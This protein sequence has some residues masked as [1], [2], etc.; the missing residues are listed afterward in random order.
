M[1]IPP[2]VVPRRAEA[3][4]L[5]QINPSG[6]VNFQGRAVGSPPQVRASSTVQQPTPYIG[7]TAPDKGLFML[8]EGLQYFN[9]EIGKLAFTQ[10]KEWESGQVEKG[11]TDAIVDPAKV[12]EVFKIGLD[13][14]AEQGLFPK[15]AHPSYRFAY[16]QQGAEN[17]ALTGLPAFLEDRAKALTS[18]DSTEPIES[19]LNTSIDEF[20]NNSGITSSPMA[21]AAFREAAFPS[22][23]RVVADTR[24]KR[25]ENF[26][27]ARLEGLEQNINGQTTGL[28]SSMSIEKESDR[29]MATGLALRNLQTTFDNIRKNYPEVNATKQFTSSFLASLNASVSNG[30]LNPREAMQVVQTAAASLKA[31]TGAW[32]DIADVQY[33]ISGIMATW[34][35]KA[36]SQGNMAQQQKNQ[37]QALL[38]ETISDV[39]EKSIV[40][41]TFTQLNSNTDLEAIGVA[42]A[43]EVYP[44]MA[45]KTDFLRRKVRELKIETQER[46]ENSQKFFN[47][48]PALE[49]LI[50]EDPEMARARLNANRSSIN[51]ETYEKYDKKINEVN[52]IK[53]FL[54][55]GGYAKKLAEIEPMVRDSIAPK[56][57][58]FE[59]DTLTSEE[60]EKI[61]DL[62]SFGEQTFR[63]LST[64]FLR[65]ELMENPA[66]RQDQ[67]SRET[68][69]MKA[70]NQAWI[71]TQKRMADYQSKSEKSS[72]ANDPNANPAKQKQQKA[73]IYGTFVRTVSLLE[74]AVDNMTLSTD[75]T[76][77]QALF[78]TLT[79]A[80][81]VDLK[82]RLAE[83]P[84]ELNSIAAKMGMLVPS[85]PE[86]PQAVASYNKII[87]IAG[88]GAQSVIKGKTEHGMP[89]DVNYIK[90]NWKNV[91]IF[92]NSEEYQA[93]WKE[94]KDALTPVSSTKN[95]LDFV[96]QAE[97]FISKATWDNK[98]WSVGFG[99][100][101]QQ[102]ETLSEPQAVARLEQELQGHAAA[103]DTAAEAANVKFTEGQR[104]A[105]ISFGFN[106]GDSVVESVIKRFG[107]DPTAMKKK[108]MEFVNETKNGQLVFSQGLQNRRLKEIAMFDS[109]AIAPSTVPAEPSTLEQLFS[110]LEIDTPEEEREFTQRQSMFSRQRTL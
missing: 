57:F 22:M 89:V 109:V 81:N 63:E 92:R 20:A 25:E 74:D 37:K 52:D 53:K 76:T 29:D 5:M 15:H 86:Y 54:D 79:T 103:V 21:Y 46:L 12:S 94:A 75:D 28:L 44:E 70:V 97:G 80:Q 71:E 35:G 47:E 26:N 84:R 69:S 85:D 10:R 90:Q 55:E 4:D 14:A 110:I 93:V 96:K 82:K 8:A 31:G 65:S 72:N 99:T 13:K 107:G 62:Q 34:E 39:L 78:E 32:A 50:D 49:Q 11:K 64:Q 36:A 67:V 41:G 17:L 45:E 7:K 104:N 91:P 106:N 3:S 43:Q 77:G 51:R 59:A 30:Q 56:G 1:A 18:A 87:G 98:Q 16:L 102:G 105:L 101:G 6:R 58:S 33:A 108:M 66:L 68:A 61:V 38:D 27:T 88:Y 83:A 42:A 60:Q 100:R 23:L 24:K 2:R 48:D 9:A 40:D 73:A 95:L 19:T